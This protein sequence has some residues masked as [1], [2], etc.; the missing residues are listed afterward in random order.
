MIE[1]ENDMAKKRYVVEQVH[2]DGAPGAPVVRK[3][4]S[5]SEGQVDKIR[6]EMLIGTRKNLNHSSD[7]I[8]V[9]NN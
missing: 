9:R 1:E 3:S 4:K 6:R 7:W 5:A 2:A 8:R